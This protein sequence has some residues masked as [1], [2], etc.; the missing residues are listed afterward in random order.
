MTPNSETADGGPTPK[1]SGR[2]LGTEL[3]REVSKM[4][5]A[6]CQVRAVSRGFRPVRRSKKV[7]M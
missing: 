4:V 5:S 7:Q 2:A 1:G 3:G 6:F